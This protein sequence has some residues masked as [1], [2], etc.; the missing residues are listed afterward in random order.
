M[1]VNLDVEAA[2][3]IGEG[4]EFRSGSVNVQRFQREKCGSSRDGLFF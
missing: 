1:T 4:I 3:E 2:T